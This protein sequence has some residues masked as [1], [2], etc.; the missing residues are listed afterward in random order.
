M[1][2]NTLPKLMWTLAIVCSSWSLPGFAEMSV[3]ISGYGS[4]SNAG[5]ETYRSTSGSV[6]LSFGIGDHVLLGLT[7]RESLENKTGLKKG[8]GT[9]GTEEYFSFTDDTDSTTNSLDL[10]IIL[11][12]GLISPFVFGGVAKKDYH[13]E[14]EYVGQH[15]ESN[16]TLFPV[17]TYGFGV[18][19][20]L[21]RDFNLK[22][23]QT[24]SPGVQT[25]LDGGSEKSVMVRDTYTQV[26]ITYKIN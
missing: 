20:M 10:T 17:P 23:S 18:A 12:N 3:G 4:R 19:I 26:G 16:V 24:Y 1:K 2:F 22:I 7:H 15:V 14:V 13:T 8:T 11:Y 9:S 21:N 6:S 5:L 25:I